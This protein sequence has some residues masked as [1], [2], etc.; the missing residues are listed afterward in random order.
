MTIS[1]DRLRC[2]NWIRTFKSKEAVD[3]G[4]SVRYTLSQTVV[5]QIHPLESKF[6]DLEVCSANVG[7]LAGRSA[8]IVEMLE[9]RSINIC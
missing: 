3:G 5:L 4:N 7:T 1:I 2:I 8:E 9:H 6:V